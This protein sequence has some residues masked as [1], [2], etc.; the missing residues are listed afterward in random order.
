MTASSERQAKRDAAT[1]LIGAFMTL[2]SYIFEITEAEVTTAMATI[3]T[4]MVHRT[5]KGI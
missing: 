2:I 3:L 5:S 4:I 1:A